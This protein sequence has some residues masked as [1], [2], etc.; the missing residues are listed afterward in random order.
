MKVGSPRSLLKKCTNQGSCDSTQ[1]GD[2]RSRNSTIDQNKYN[3]LVEDI[4]SP[5]MKTPLWGRTDRLRSP[6]RYSGRI[7]HPTEER[8]FSTELNFVRLCV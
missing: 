2:V 4:H 5:T 8:K 1:V 6:E 3:F 7:E